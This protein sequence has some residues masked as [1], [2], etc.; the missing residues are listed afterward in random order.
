MKY[1]PGFWTNM[2]PVEERIMFKDVKRNIKNLC[3]LCFVVPQLKKGF[4]GICKE[5]LF[6]S[7]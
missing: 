4:Y 7:Y 5:T 2:N 1:C 3:C 6:F